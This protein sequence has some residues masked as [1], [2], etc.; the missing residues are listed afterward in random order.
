LYGLFLFFVASYP[1]NYLQST[2]TKSGVVSYFA[3]TFE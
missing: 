1:Q 3:G 2:Y